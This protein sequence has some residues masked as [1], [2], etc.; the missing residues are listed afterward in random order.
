[1]RYSG[2]TRGFQVS[3]AL[4][5]GFAPILATAMVGMLGGTMGVSMMLVMLGIMTLAATIFGHETR[6]QPLKL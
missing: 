2:A 3:A 5:G 6:G 1:M 4:G